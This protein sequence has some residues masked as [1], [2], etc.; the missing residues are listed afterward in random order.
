VTRLVPLLAQV[1]I[2]VAVSCAL[3][4]GYNVVRRDYDRVE[5]GR[6]YFPKLHRPPVDSGATGT[7]PG[8]QT[9]AQAV[10]AT[11][12]DEGEAKP[13]KPPAKD[14]GFQV[15]TYEQAREMFEGDMYAMGMCV[16][17][18]ARNEDQYLEC[19]IPGA[20]RLDHYRL[21]QCLPD[22]IPVAMGAD[23]VV[24]YCTGGNCE[25]SLFAAEDLL[26]AGVCWDNVWVYEGG[27]EEW[28]AKGA[29]TEE[30]EAE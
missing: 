28:V 2:L 25:D 30:E 20:R 8:Q 24:L 4:L 7:E 1:G 21:D 9:D 26:E 23:Q 15:M 14:H 18:D 11:T 19:H 29:P 22:L 13:G 3:A 5:L 17:I 10:V 16:F 6:N 27:I 12:E